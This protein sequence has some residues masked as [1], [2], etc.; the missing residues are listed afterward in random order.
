LEDTGE[1]IDKMIGCRQWH[2]GQLKSAFRSS[3]SEYYKLSPF[4][5]GTVWNNRRL[6]DPTTIATGGL[7]LAD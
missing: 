6:T 3:D 1:A 7:A 5:I 4:D 2:P